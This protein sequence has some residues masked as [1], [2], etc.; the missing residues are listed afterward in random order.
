MSAGTSTRTHSLDGRSSAGTVTA[1]VTP[2]KKIGWPSVSSI[3]RSVSVSE[4]HT[5]RCIL[6]VWPAVV[7]TVSGFVSEMPISVASVYF[8]NVSPPIVSEPLPAVLTAT[9]V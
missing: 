1:W 6:G 3:L 4:R 7:G 9:E 5:S 2:P 8:R